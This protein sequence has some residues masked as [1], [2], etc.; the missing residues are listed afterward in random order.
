MVKQ[1]W[2]T[3][4]RA[5]AES[6]LLAK[7]MSTLARHEPWLG[8]VDTLNQARSPP[9]LTDWGVVG[10]CSTRLQHQPSRNQS[11][12]VGDVAVPVSVRQAVLFWALRS[13]DSRP[14]L[15]WR[16]SSSTVLSQVCLGWPGRRLQFL[17]G[18]E[19]INSQWNNVRWK[20]QVHLS[21]QHIDVVGDCGKQQLYWCRQCTWWT[22]GGLEQTPMEPHKTLE[23]T[24]TA[25][26]QHLLR[27]TCQEWRHL[28]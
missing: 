10:W 27:P 24:T 23:L 17:G 12:L 13:P 26:V 11:E 1:L 19:L 9:S 21:H 22:A 6:R 5:R 15:N 20:K 3:T 4:P 7:L 2:R 14:R 28:L 8:Q 25:V 16:R 18:R